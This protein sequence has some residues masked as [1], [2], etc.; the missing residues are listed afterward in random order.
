MNVT[1]CNHL[2]NDGN[3]NQPFALLASDHGAAY[4]C[5]SCLASEVRRRIETEIPAELGAAISFDRCE[6]VADHRGTHC[7][8]CQV[9][10]T[11]AISLLWGQLKFEV[12]STAAN[13]VMKLLQHFRKRYGPARL[14]S[15][16]DEEGQETAKTTPVY[17]KRLLKAESLNGD[18]ARAAKR[19]EEARE[20]RVRT[21]KTPVQRVAVIPPR[22]EAIVA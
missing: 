6:H 9:S 1:L 16:E 8:V 22:R 10:G 3:L 18:R 11:A 15:I 5:P 17:S 2:V 14:R 21:H 4:V 12:S 13:R 7:H 20:Q 19:W